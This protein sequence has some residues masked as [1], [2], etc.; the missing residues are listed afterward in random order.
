[1]TAVNR[2]MLVFLG[3]AGGVRV[4]AGQGKGGTKKVA[5]RNSL[6]PFFGSDED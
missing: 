3:L 4:R 6:R 1:M 5:I 2:A